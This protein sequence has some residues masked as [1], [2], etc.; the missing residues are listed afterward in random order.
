VNKKPTNALIIQCIGTQY[1]STCFGTSK[2]H[3]QGVKHNPA[4]IGAHCRAEPR[5][6][7]AVYCNRRRDGRDDTQYSPTCFGTSKFHNQAVK[8]DPAEIGAQCRGKP[9]RMGAV[10]CNMRR[11]GRDIRSGRSGDRIPVGTRFFAPVQTGA[12]AHPA[13]CTVGT[14]SFPGVESG[15]DVML[16]PHPL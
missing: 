16:T 5:R 1:S 6:M 9:R 7:G 4:E 10:Y 11:D 8:H 2:C 13:S 15:W 14:S 3:N 12:G